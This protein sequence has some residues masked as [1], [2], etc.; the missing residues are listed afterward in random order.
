MEVT[1][2]TFQDYYPDHR[3]VVSHSVFNHTGTLVASADMDGVVKLWSPYPDVKLVLPTIFF[4]I[5]NS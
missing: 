2:F 4:F 1:F 3:A 5:I